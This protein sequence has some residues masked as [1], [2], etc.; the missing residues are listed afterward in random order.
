MHNLDLTIADITKIEGKASCDIKVRDGK[1]EKVDFSIAEYKRFYTQAIRGKDMLALPQLTARICGTCSNAHLLCALKAVENAVD[2][3]PSEQT[4]LLRKLLNF[5]LIIRDH[6]LH[7]YVF[8]MPD[9]F[10]KDS[11]LDFD[12]NNPREHKYL[13]DAF[14]VKAAGNW[15]SKRVGGRSVHAPFLTVGGF[16]KLPDIKE[17]QKSIKELEDIR[18]KIL[19]L[20]TLF[21]ENPMSLEIKDIDFAAVTDKDYS[22]LYGDLVRTDEDVIAVEKYGEYLEHVTTPYSHAS[23]YKFG[24]KVYMVGALARLNLMKDNLNSVTLGDIGTIIDIFPSKNIFHN[25]LAQAIEILH[26]VDSSLEILSD[27]E[28]TNEKSIT[29]KRCAGVGI[30]VIEAPRG[31]LYYRLEVDESGKIKT[32]EIVV[33][34]GQNQICIEDSIKY[35]LENNID[36][37]ENKEELELEIEKIVRAFDPC[38]SCASH[39]LKVKW[40]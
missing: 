4:I 29:P 39:F 18:P 26:A 14:S 1:V 20:I 24:G 8:V 35:Y 28:I 7:L 33:P 10:G 5:G 16:I 31:A 19:D 17:L 21:A 34:T 22:F 23:R 13:D 37:F 11:I 9:I 38:M 3:I 12:E 2:L 6:A 36:K 25:N 27:L 15:L 32:G 30:G 40:S